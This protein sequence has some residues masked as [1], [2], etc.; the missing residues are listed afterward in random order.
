MLQSGL[1]I[2]CLVLLVTCLNAYKLN[3][4][5]RATSWKYASSSR[6]LHASSPRGKFQDM[7]SFFDKLFNA[8][9][10]Q[11]QSKRIASVSDEKIKSNPIISETVTKKVVIIGKPYCTVYSIYLRLIA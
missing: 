10:N 3:P 9:A 6:R 5:V 1:L 11:G 8:G 7:R 2:V 4:F